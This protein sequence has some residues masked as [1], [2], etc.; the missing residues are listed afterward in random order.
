V[1]DGVGGLVASQR[2]LAEVLVGLGQALHLGE[3]GVEGHG[4][5][6]G[7]LA[8]VQVGRP[9]ELLLDHQRLLQQLERRRRKGVR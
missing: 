1:Q 4:R 5:V 6:A 8:H 2:L 7:V 9:S 3:A